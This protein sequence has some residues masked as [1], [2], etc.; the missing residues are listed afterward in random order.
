MLNYYH[1]FKVL[2]TYNLSTSKTHIFLSLNNFIHYFII[3][4]LINVVRYHKNNV[5]IDPLYNFKSH[6]NIFTRYYRL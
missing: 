1:D 5:F 2:I 4:S 6:K 3:F